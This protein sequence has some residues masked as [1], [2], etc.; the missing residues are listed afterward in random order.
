[1]WFY[2]KLT[3]SAS[4]MLLAC[5]VVN[6]DS[7]RADISRADWVL[8]VREHSVQ[9]IEPL[10]RLLDTFIEAQGNK[11]VIRYPGGDE[12]ERWTT[13]LIAYLVSLGIPSSF[14]EQEPGSG[15]Q[16]MIRL[17]VEQNESKP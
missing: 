1:M 17:V 9:Q 16:G 7:W 15:R 3:L 5:T 2:C 8:N 13:Q 12:G 10:T 14:I 4:L 6:A 11:I